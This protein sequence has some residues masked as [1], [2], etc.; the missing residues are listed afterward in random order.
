MGPLSSA[1]LQQ[2]EKATPNMQNITAGEALKG[3]VNYGGSVDRLSTGDSSL[4]LP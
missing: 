4:M 2:E 3:L 1:F